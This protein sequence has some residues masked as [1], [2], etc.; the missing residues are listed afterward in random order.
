[1]GIIMFYA[2]SSVVLAFFLGGVLASG[3]SCMLWR[4][5]NNES[6]VK[7]ERSHCDHCNHVLNA[8]DLIPVFGYLIRGGKCK[9]CGK[10]IPSSSFFCELICSTVFAVGAVI[11]IQATGL[12]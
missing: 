12:L 9:Y 1:M 7:V 4:K 6:W 8:I 2:I 11:I 10:P 3:I 5:K